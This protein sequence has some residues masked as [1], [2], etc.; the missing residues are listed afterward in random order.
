M[1]GRSES[2]VEAMVQTVCE[3]THHVGRLLKARDDYA[4]NRQKDT[5]GLENN[6]LDL[7]KVS[8]MSYIQMR[9]PAEALQ[10]EKGLRSVIA[11]MRNTWP[12]SHVDALEKI[13]GQLAGQIAN[14][15]HYHGTRV[16]AARKAIEADICR[17]YQVAKV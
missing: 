1:A 10:S 9:V 14:T 15:R 12:R 5:E 2:E 17:H 6:V 13:R 8:H 3:A 7:E 16:E 11:Q 4:S